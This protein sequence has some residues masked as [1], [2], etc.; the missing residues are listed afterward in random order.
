MLRRGRKKRPFSPTLEQ[1]EN[2][3]LLAAMVTEFMAINDSVLADEQGRF[4][5]WI[6]VH[7]PHG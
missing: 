1:L 6:E 5:D 4:S 3:H 7:N 2:R